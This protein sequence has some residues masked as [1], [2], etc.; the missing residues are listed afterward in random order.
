MNLHAIVVRY[1]SPT[2]TKPGRVRMTSGRHYAGKSTKVISWDH[3]LGHNIT[4]QASA[5]LTAHGFTVLH[6]AELNA[7]E[8]V[9][10]VRE[11]CSLDA[12]PAVWR[13]VTL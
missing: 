11:H 5:W 1:V 6:T 13:K 10:L 9:V 4:D 8:S 2:N 7:R 3:E 12:D